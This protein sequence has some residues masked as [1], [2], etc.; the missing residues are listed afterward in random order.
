MRM[1][2]RFN[3]GVTAYPGLYFSGLHTIKSGLLPGGGDDAAHI[4]RT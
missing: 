1:G 2:T 4:A 3:G